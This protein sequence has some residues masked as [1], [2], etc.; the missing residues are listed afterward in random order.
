MPHIIM[1][2]AAYYYAAC[3]VFT[4]RHLW[5]ARPLCD[6]GKLIEPVPPAL[7]DAT[8]EPLRC[9]TAQLGAAHARAATRHWA[10]LRGGSRCAFVTQSLLDG[11]R[12]HGRAR[13][14][15]GGAEG[16]VCATP[17]RSPARTHS[18]N[19]ESVSAAVRAGTFRPRAICCDTRVFVAIYPAIC[20]D[21]RLFVAARGYL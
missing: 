6:D 11:A 9:T 2:H 5:L 18:L 16:L 17:Q 15:S 12:G 3:C 14:T 1:L 13:G 8:S 7:A 21:T 10:A 20:S 19:G 4:R